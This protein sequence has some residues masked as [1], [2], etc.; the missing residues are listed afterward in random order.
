MQWIPSA[1]A[2]LV[3][4]SQTRRL[5][6]TGSITKVPRSKPSIRHTLTLVVGWTTMTKYYAT[7]W[8]TGSY[9]TITKDQIFLSSR[10][11]SRDAVIDDPV[12]KPSNWQWVRIAFIYRSDDI[13]A[14]IIAV[15][16]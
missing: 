5:G 7:A 11:H 14:D 4:I 10:P 6:S 3:L 8:K 15:D 2:P 13:F 9:P 1:L 12:G 16:G